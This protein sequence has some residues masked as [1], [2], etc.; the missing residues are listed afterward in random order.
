MTL[1]RFLRETR[2]AAGIV[3]VLLTMMTLGGVAFVTD[4]LWL[5]HHRDLLKNAAD[6][7][8]TATTNRLLALPESISDDDVKSQLQ[9]LAIRYVRTNLVGNVPEDALARMDETLK[10]DVKLNRRMGTV[11]VS[12]SAEMGGTLLSKQLLAYAGPKDGITV[13]SGAEGSFE[14]TE[15]VLVLDVTTSMLRKMGRG[16][17]GPSRLSIV[18]RAA[19]DLVEVFASN[20][21]SPVAVGI[22]PWN[23][24]VR[25][26]GAT[27]E[28][29]EDNGW[30]VYPTERTYPHP[31]RGELGAD[32]HPPERQAL[33]QRERIPG[34]CRRWAGC[35]DRRVLDSSLRQS[36][37]AAL[38]SREP[39]LMTFFTDQTA[40]P[41]LEY[42]SYAC[43]AYTPEEA[44]VNS[45]ETPYCYDLDR[46][47]AGENTCEAGYI[48][49]GGLRRL[50]PQDDCLG[51]E[52][53]PLNTDLAAVRNA[54]RGLLPF[55]GST[56]SPVGIAWAIRLLDSSWRDVWGHPEH[57]MDENTE[58]QKIIVLLTDGEDNHLTGFDNNRQQGCTEAKNKGITIFTIAALPP[59]NVGHALDRALQRCSSQADDPGGTYF[60]TNNATPDALERAF[61]DIGRQLVSLRRT[62]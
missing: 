14:A 7:A 34:A 31:T 44:R 50:T 29:W 10:V 59:A 6:A 17:S 28:R 3:G 20:E 55:G 12:A 53:M 25:L 32:R 47:P 39:F 24:R 52:I 30:A 23:Y 51:P 56:Y 33:P 22:V 40:K 45:S 5:T 46:A 13:E 57:P 37:S 4:H 19:E 48:Q 16:W 1:F 42:A 58:V 35:L 61:A 21:N 15:I 38:P 49:P 8:V 11:A 26:N 43:Q 54:I 60:F 36:F 9:A 27:R 18:K 41:Y 2:A 62:Y